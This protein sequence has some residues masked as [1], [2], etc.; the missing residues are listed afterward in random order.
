MSMVIH[1]KSVTNERITH[2]EEHNPLMSL[3][4]K[5]ASE[6][7]QRPWMLSFPC[8]ALTA[9]VVRQLPAG[10]TSVQNSEAL[11]ISAEIWNKLSLIIWLL[12]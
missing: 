11:F 9:D 1:V 10:Y 7:A 8:G 2:K 12:K 3:R 5:G 6:N 4:P